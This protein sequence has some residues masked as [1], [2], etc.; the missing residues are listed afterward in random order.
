MTIPAQKVVI[1]AYEKAEE[2]VLARLDPEEVSL[3]ADAFRVRV[4]KT[5][6]DAAAPVIQRSQR[7]RTRMAL[8][9]VAQAAE[10]Y[11][12]DFAQSSDARRVELRAN[13]FDATTDAWMLLRPN[14]PCCDLHN[15]HCEPPGDLCC[16]RCTEARHP[17][18]PPGVTCVLAAHQAAP[19]PGQP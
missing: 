4:I 12:N 2:A 15:V 16:G 9:R 10:S 13:L 1:E 5:I 14:E 8:E 6:V 11:L 19:T 7:F 18:H 3:P 17:Q